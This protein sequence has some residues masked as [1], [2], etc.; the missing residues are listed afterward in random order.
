MTS[1]NT[2]LISADKEIVIRTIIPITADVT[3]PSG[4]A[5]RVVNG[6]GFSI[7]SGKILTIN[8]P[9]E[10]GPYQVFYG[11]GYYNVRGLKEA[12]GLWWGSDN[13][14]K[15]AVVSSTERRTFGV[16]V[17]HE[18]VAGGPLGDVR[19]HGENEVPGATDTTTIINTALALGGNVTIPPGV[20]LVTGVT[21]DVPGTTI[22]L[23][24]GAILKLKDGSNA[25][26]ISAT[27][28]DVT[29]TGGEIDGN[30]ANQ[31]RQNYGAAGI[32]FISADN[33][34]VLGTYIHDTAGN[35]VFG[36]DSQNLSVRLN[37]ILNTDIQC[38]FIKAQSG[39]DVLNPDVSYNVV[40][41]SMSSYHLP[42]IL[43][44]RDNGGTIKKATA[45][46][47]HVTLPTTNLVADDIGIGI[48]A[49]D[50]VVDS[51]V[52]TGGYMS[53]SIDR[54]TGGSGTG[55]NLTG[56][57]WGVEF[58]G[59]SNCQL[60]GGTINALTYGVV[61]D[62]TD[63]N[64]ND[65]GITGVNIKA[66]TC[67]VFGSMSSGYRMDR[68]AVV[69]CP[70]TVNHAS[71]NAV[72]LKFGDNCTVVGNPMKNLVAGGVAV[73]LDRSDIATVTGNSVLGF[74]VCTQA[75]DYQASAQTYTNVSN[76]YVP[77]GNVF[78]LS[79]LRTFGTGCRQIGNTG[80]SHYY[81]ILDM[82]TNVRHIRSTG[83]PEG[84]YAAGVGSIYHRTN[85]VPGATIYIKE[86]G[87]GNTGWAAVATYS[88][89]G[90]G[91]Y[92]PVATIKAN[93]ASNPVVSKCQYLR[94]GTSVTVSGIITVEPSAVGAN[95]EVEITL[96]VVSDLA[97]A[98]DVAGVAFSA[99]N[100]GQGAAIIANPA[101][102][103][104]L[105]KWF[106]SSVASS[107][108]AFTFTY[109]VKL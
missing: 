57:V 60:T 19:V 77:N 39:V 84:V 74:L 1:W 49:D 14:P 9:F 78:T 88:G 31:T 17:G 96:P 41:R 87:T 4:V 86:S 32:E 24:P 104:A 44:Q 51:N 56:A 33:G 5:V 76:N 38:V 103:K 91:T 107:V 50:Y 45:N 58:A 97:A 83:S 20:W 66:G 53:I 21:A 6:G 81:D 11:P 61:I 36:Q 52:V 95:T 2:P 99:T 79:G 105:I 65:N 3:Y 62:G 12:R 63:A 109:E 34:K 80:S 73:F 108:M 42:A 28:A 16:L 82:Q 100:A 22:M 64:S 92:T 23:M 46:G 30:A 15:E 59:S 69:G 27:A 102:N 85:G 8:G 72:Y 75:Y 48:R 37:R 43:I 55:N 29:V 98:E 13:Y 68:T 67:G 89:I 94:M 90:Y 106:S 18:V 47:N 54:S 25:P 70:I 40:D 93:I 7:S 26:V 101:T 71:G 10:A 35:G